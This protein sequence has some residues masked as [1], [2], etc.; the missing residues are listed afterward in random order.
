MTSGDEPLLTIGEVAGRAGVNTSHIRFYER[1][2][3]LPE[4]ERLSGRR[5]YRADVVDRLSIIDVAQR[6]GLTLEEIAP[7]TGP[8]TRSAEAGLH[9]RRLAQEKLPHIDA[10]IARAQAV[11]HW[12]E[13]AQSCDCASVDV[14]GLFVDPNLVPPDGDVDLDVR[15][16]RRRLA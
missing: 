14:C 7:L 8:G 15:H 16:V 2:G 5:R 3:V 4:P 13:V 11:K 9:I 12:L 1:V 10:L 6:A